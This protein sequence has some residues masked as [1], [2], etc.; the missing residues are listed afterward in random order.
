MYTILTATRFWSDLE[1]K[2]KKVNEEG[3]LKAKKI[4]VFPFLG[5]TLD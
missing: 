2:S 1:M 3:H 5:D 4:K